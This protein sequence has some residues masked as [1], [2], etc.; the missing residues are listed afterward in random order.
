MSQLNPAHNHNLKAPVPHGSL[1]LSTVARARKADIIII[2]RKLKCSQKSHKI[3]DDDERRKTGKKVS[4]SENEHYP[5]RRKFIPSS[6]H[7]ANLGWLA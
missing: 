1:K 5:F 3:D 6:T 4:R 2:I 7:Q